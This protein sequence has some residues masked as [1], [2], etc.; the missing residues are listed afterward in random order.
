MHTLKYEN[1]LKRNKMVSRKVNTNLDSVLRLEGLEAEHPLSRLLSEGVSF[2]FVSSSPITVMVLLCCLPASSRQGAQCECLIPA[3]YLLFGWMGEQMNGCCCLCS[4]TGVTVLG[5]PFDKLLTFRKW[6]WS[7]PIKT[8]QISFHTW[9]LI[10]QLHHRNQ[11]L[12]CELSVVSDIIDSESG[13]NLTVV[14][15]PQEPDNITEADSKHK[16]TQLR[17]G[18][19]NTRNGCCKQENNTC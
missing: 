14:K 19:E 1:P 11:V 8:P 2:I 12:L 7:A 6:S 15:S 17:T 10:G 16:Q 18:I 5:S 9:S 13:S 3:S 4:I